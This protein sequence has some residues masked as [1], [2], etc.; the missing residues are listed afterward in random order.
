MN[1]SNVLFNDTQA[2]YPL[3]KMSWCTSIV[4]VNY[5]AYILFVLCPEILST[6]FESTLTYIMFR[7]V[8]IAHPQ[9]FLIFQNHIVS[10]VMS[11]ISLTLQIVNPW[12]K[13][14]CFNIYYFVVN[15]ISFQFHLI[16]WMSVSVLR[17]RLIGGYKSQRLV[18][19]DKL[20]MKTTALTW[21]SIVLI[22]GL[23]LLTG[24]A[25][26]F[27]LSGFEGVNFKFVLGCNYFFW[28]STPLLVSAVI[29]YIL[30]KR[31]KKRRRSIGPVEI[32]LETISTSVPSD[33]SA[34]SSNC[35][36]GKN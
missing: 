10:L 21:L 25:W 20:K 3:T 30:M 27:M 29:Y 22:V 8:E 24:Q 15:F 26:R 23:I 36:V 32:E 13:L 33:T 4:E 14:Q 34:Q 12:A 5:T 1:I 35:Q 7:T 6:A 28:T 2:H 19:F 31:I 16:T 18:D 9:F 11:S 17:Y